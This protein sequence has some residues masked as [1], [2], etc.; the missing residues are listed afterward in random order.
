M[1]KALLPM[2][3][4]LA[5]C[6][7]GAA[8]LI[9]TKARAAPSGFKPMMIALIGTDGGKADVRRPVMIAQGSADSGREAGQDRA[10][11]RMH[12]ERRAQICQTIYAHKVGELAFLEARLSL[13]PAQTPLFSRWK[14]VSLNIA[15]Q[16][17]G[18]CASHHR[19]EQPPTIMD[20]LTREEGLLKQRLADI[21]AERP[22]LA[23]LYDSLTASQRDA[24]RHGG[25]GRGMMGH[26]G[27]GGMGP[28]GGPPGMGPGPE[29]LPPEPPPPQ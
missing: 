9:G 8:A 4:S 7:L 27:P 16:H 18:D 1:R 23:A 6:L 26:P 5:L 24:L 29:G 22:A 11:G 28:M 12:A 19:P 13:T 25:M 20:R 17:Q 3:A 15:R 2:I 21:Q 14:T 10:M